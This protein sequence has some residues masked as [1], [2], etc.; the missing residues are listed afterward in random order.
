MTNVSSVTH[1]SQ[2]CYPAVGGSNGRAFREIEDELRMTYLSCHSYS[3]IDRFSIQGTGLRLT[4]QITEGCRDESRLLK[5]KSER[6]L[7]RIDVLVDT[8]D[9]P[10]N[11]RR[12]AHPYNLHF[13]LSLSAGCV[14]HLNFEGLNDLYRVGSLECDP[15]TTPT[16]DLTLTLREGQPASWGQ[17]M[18]R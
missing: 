1:A 14:F 4:N 12:L 15:K 13:S 3:Y 5:T 6:A 11:L 8:R 2:L 16:F 10:C 17:R 9:F 7:L 18:V